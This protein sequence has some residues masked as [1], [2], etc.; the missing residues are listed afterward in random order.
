MH[1]ISIWARKPKAHAKPYTM[2]RQCGCANTRWPLLA[3]KSGGQSVTFPIL[4]AYK[5]GQRLRYP[6]TAVTFRALPAPA[7]LPLYLPIGQPA[8]RAEPLP[9]E[10][11]LG[12]PASRVLDTLRPA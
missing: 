3:L 9:Q 4:D 5:F 12:R 2:A 1:R 7:Y 8:V 11:F 6:V 10:I